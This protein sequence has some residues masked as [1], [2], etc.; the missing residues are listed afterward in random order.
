MLVAVLPLPA[1]T[2]GETRI[3]RFLQNRLSG[4]GREVGVTGFSGA[5]SGAARVDALTI[6][7]ADGVWL[8]LR[9]A[10]LHCS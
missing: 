3:E 2:D 7:A 1:W 9:D 6:T 8:T 5:S 4:A 10:E